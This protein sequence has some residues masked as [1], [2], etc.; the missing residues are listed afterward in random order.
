M[1]T[2][3]CLRQKV[4]IMTG[5]RILEFDVLRS[6]A[7]IWIIA[8]WHLAN[9]FNAHS[10]LG[11]ITNNELCRNVTYIMLSLF[12]FLSGLF[13]NTKF[14]NIND[15]KGFYLKKVKRFYPLY[16][17]AT[18]TLYITPTPHD[19]SFY[20]SLGQLIMSLFG[21]STLL[22]N[23]PSTLWFMD[24][25]LFFIMITPVLTWK[26]N[27]VR[28]IIVMSAIFILI[29][30]ASRKM[31]VIDSRF[32]RYSPFYFGGLLMTPNGFLKL[33]KKHGLKCILLALLII[34]IGKHH[35]FV[36]IVIFA[37][38]IIWGGDVHNIH[39]QKS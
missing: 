35:I 17:L 21:V 9:Y 14:E 5:K 34:L 20:T 12:M 4:S 18:L 6:L 13:T 39:M 26:N 36:D 7:V 23:A 31:N 8:I 3:E 32:L 28:E 11:E 15:V 2:I 22:N 1:L 38:V 30:V 25:L 24:M 29:Y 33:C 10:F 19:M 37:L 27:K 16:V